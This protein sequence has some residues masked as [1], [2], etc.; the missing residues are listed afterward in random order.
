VETEASEP[1]PEIHRPAG[2][3]EGDIDIAQLYN[4]GVYEDIRATIKGQAK[5]V[6]LS[7]QRAR[8]VASREG[9]FGEELQMLN[10]EIQG[11]RPEFL[12]TR[13]WGQD[14]QPEWARGLIWDCENP[15]KCIPM[16][17]SSASRPVS[18]GTLDA[19]FLEQGRLM[20]WPDK[21]ML[22]QLSSGCGVQGDSRCEMVTVVMG[23]HQGLQRDIG[24]AAKSIESDSAPEKGWMSKGSW[25]LP[26]VPGRMVA[27]NIA[28]AEKFHL[29]EEGKV[30][31]K[32]KE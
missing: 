16:Q 23:H 30:F 7:L 19:F 9:V 27:K 5:A 28:E 11:I 18:H 4:E 31:H 2:A 1:L 20:Q 17:P 26:T 6:E 3:P 15:R 21:E 25:D 12:R 13:V 14:Q 22:R 24:P 32:E 29:D 10:E 8:L